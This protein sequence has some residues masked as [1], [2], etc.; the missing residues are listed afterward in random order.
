[1]ESRFA[2]FGLQ[3]D[4]TGYELTGNKR[5]EGIDIGLIKAALGAHEK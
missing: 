1:V 2:E 3:L 5:A 4:S